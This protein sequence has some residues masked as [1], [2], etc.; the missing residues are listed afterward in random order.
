MDEILLNEDSQRAVMY[1]KSIA[2]R[3]ILLE[4]AKMS[5]HIVGDQFC[6]TKKIDGYMHLVFLRN[7]EAYA[8]GTGG[9]LIS[10]LSCL[11]AVKDDLEKA[12]IQSAVIAAELYMPREGGRPRCGDVPSALAD[13]SLKDN[14]SLA[15]FDIV[16]L[17][18]VPFQR[19]HY[20][21]VHERLSEIFTSAQSSPVEMRMADSVQSV[22]TIF[23]EWVTEE[24]AEG[25]VVHS[26]SE[27]V[28]KVKPRHTVD[29]AVV[30]Y[31]TFEEGVRE[32][33]Y[34]VMRPDG[35]FQVFGIGSSGLSEGNRM[36]LFE[37][38]SQMDV[39]SQYV[40]TDS[41]GVAYRMVRPE[42][43][44]ECTVIDLMSC[45][46]DG[47]AKMNPVVSF[48]PERGWIRQGNAAGVR[49]LGL[50]LERIREDKTCNEVDVRISQLSDLC[51]FESIEKE[52]E[53]LP[54]S[55]I[56]ARR[57]FRKVSGDK[58]MIHKFL[59]WKTNKEESGRYPAYIFY[60]T[61]Y[62]SSRKEPLKRDMSWSSDEGQAMQFLDDAIAEN[63]KK[64][65]EELSV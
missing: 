60:H 7:G 61:D 37:T 3:F 64:G 59:V 51:P 54:L 33:V 27:I 4:A 15:P 2:S 45:G 57:V 46:S 52:P 38:L 53:N 28:W 43:V 63:I 16:E 31:T 26:E 62:S 5:A 40:Q 21:E 42:I 6:V 18:G 34:A 23:D 65:W 47:K 41:R 12:G 22:K 58:I 48:D 1:K 24:G 50:K 36:P 10:D 56:L 11:H 35:R 55:T 49:A 20:K 29:V 17:D 9:R 32:L 13:P 44:A 39:E 25:L 19:N 8:F 30:G 14:L